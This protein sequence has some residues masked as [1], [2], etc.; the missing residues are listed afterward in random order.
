[1][2]ESAPAHQLSNPWAG[3]AQPNAGFFDAL[4]LA[5]DMASD[6]EGGL[7]HWSA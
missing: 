1:M 5:S 3:D 7:I 4:Q 2:F 6:I